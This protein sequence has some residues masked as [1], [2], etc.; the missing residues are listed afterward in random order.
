MEAIC[1]L[2]SA[3]FLLPL[4][5][6]T[7][8]YLRLGLII[9]ANDINIPDIDNLILNT[10][11]GEIKFYSTIFGGRGCLRGCGFFRSNRWSVRAAI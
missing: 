3:Y 5:P 6:L 11:L 7:I 10:P 4:S 9:L 1:L 8:F 2:P